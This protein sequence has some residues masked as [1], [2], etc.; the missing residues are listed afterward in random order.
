[1]EKNLSALF[2]AY[3]GNNKKLKTYKIVKWNIISMF[4]I[5]IS[6]RDGGKQAWVGVL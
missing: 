4:N 6:P 3:M 1:M 2:P 5:H